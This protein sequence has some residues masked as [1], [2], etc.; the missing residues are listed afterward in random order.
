MCFFHG[1]GRF[2]SLSCLNHKKRDPPSLQCDEIRAMM[3]HGGGTKKSCVGPREN[4][5]C[6]M[7]NCSMGAAHFLPC[8]NRKR[9]PSCSLVSC[10]MGG[11]Q[12]YILCR[13]RNPK[14]MMVNC[15]VGVGD[16]ISFV[17]P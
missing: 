13:R 8:M 11:R 16:F 4:S 1:V 3:F 15:S 17:N 2:S 10:S 5:M 9:N 6:I 7:V 12:N 14:F